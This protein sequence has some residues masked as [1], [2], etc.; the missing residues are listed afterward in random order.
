[1]GGRVRLITQRQQLRSDAELMALQQGLC[2]GCQAE[3]PADAPS[4]RAWGFRSGA[5]N[6]VCVPEGL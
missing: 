1:M 5:P 2:A 4:W 6:K 3:F